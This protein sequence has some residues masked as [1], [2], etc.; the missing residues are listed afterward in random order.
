MHLNTRVL[1]TRWRTR[2]PRIRQPPALTQHVSH[3]PDSN[4]ASG[5]VSEASDLVSEASAHTDLGKRQEWMSTQV[6]LSVPPVTAMLVL[7]VEV[8]ESASHTHSSQTR[9]ES[10]RLVNSSTFHSHTPVQTQGR[11][12][13]RVWAQVS[14]ALSHCTTRLFCSTASNPKERDILPACIAAFARVPRAC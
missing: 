10:E 14:C 1:P 13:A 8:A 6:A 12:Q 11:A 7:A 5:L 4:V 2:D 9:R 3:R